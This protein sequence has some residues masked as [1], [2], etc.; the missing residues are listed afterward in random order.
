MPD[1]KVVITD[2]SDPDNSLEAQVLQGSGLS[3]HL[4]RLQ[5]KAPDALIPNVADADALIVQWASIN[6]HVIAALQ[7]CLVISRYGVGVDMVDLAA[8][9]ERN[10]PVANVPDFCIEEVSLQTIGFIIDLNRRTFAQVEFTRAGQWGQAPLGISAPR[11]LSTQTLGVIGLGNI[12]RAVAT[13]AA[14]LGLRLLGYDPYVAPDVMAGLGVQA[15]TLDELLRSA[16]YVTLHCPLVPETHHLIGAAQ[17]A[18][19]KPEAYLINLSR[20][21]VVDQ[22]ALCDALARGSIAGAALDVLD[23]EPPRPDEPILRLPNVLITPHASSWSVEALAQLRR[24]TA[25]NVVD[26]LQGRLPRSV[27]NRAALG[28]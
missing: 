28:L 26:V 17:L 23:P 14:H 20:G 24:Q 8:A 6:R 4:V 19:M 12:G 1:Y 13:K 7:H 2:F 16:D 25:Q 15:V 27:V 10:I 22:A 18:L 21:P 11:R 9:A 5:T 3:I